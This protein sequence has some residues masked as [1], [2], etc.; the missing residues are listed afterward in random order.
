MPISSAACATNRTPST[1]QHHII[2][3]LLYQ[4]SRDDWIR[5]SVPLLPKQV[6]NQTPDTSRKSRRSDS[7]RRGILSVYTHL[8]PRQ[9]HYQAMATPRKSTSLSSCGLKTSDHKCFS[10]IS[11]AICVHPKLVICLASSGLLTCTSPYSSMYALTK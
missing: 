2:F 5:T 1:I 11:R 10:P 7:N 9:A 8:F 6:G 4:R 3:P